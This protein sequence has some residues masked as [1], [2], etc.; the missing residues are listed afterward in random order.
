M[1]ECSCHW[2]YKWQLYEL[3]YVRCTVFMTRFDAI[4]NT[5]T[6]PLAAKRCA[7]MGVLG[8]RDVI[9]TTSIRIVYPRAP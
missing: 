2:Q 4:G 3:R 6:P 9:P 7:V 8:S 1:V 5:S